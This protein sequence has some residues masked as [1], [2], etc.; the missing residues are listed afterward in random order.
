M[1]DILVDAG[2]LAAWG[3]YA[4]QNSLLSGHFSTESPDV[5]R[6]ACRVLRLQLAPLFMGKEEIKTPSVIAQSFHEE[7]RK[8]LVQMTLQ[9]KSALCSGK[10]FWHWE[11]D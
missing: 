6:P 5:A 2:L 7:A 9:K 10:D 4:G 1:I 11:N 8:L 3:M